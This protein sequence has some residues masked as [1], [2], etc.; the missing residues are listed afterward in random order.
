MGNTIY[1]GSRTDPTYILTNA[2]VRTVTAVLSSALIGDEL[3]IDQCSIGIITEA[4]LIAYGQFIPAG[5]SGLI[6]ADGLRFRSAIWGTGFRP[7]L[8]YGTPIYWESNGVLMGKFF[9]QSLDRTSQID[10]T[11]VAVSRVGLLD[12]Q[13][14][15]GG[16]YTGES[17]TTVLAD[18]LGDGVPYTIAPE[19]QGQSIYNWLPIASRRE[20][21]HQLLFA[22]GAMI[23]KDADGELYFGFPDPAIV[24]DV[25]DE[26][27]YTDGQSTTIQPTNRVELTEHS[28]YN[29]DTDEAVTLFDNSDGTSGSAA[30]QMVEFPDAPI[31]DLQASDGLTISWSNC[32]A[33][34]VSGI[35]ILTGKKYT[36]VTR[37]ITR[38][39]EGGDSNGVEPITKATLVSVANAENVADRL[40]NYYATAR[41]IYGSI[42]VRG[43]LPGQRVRLKD[44]FYEQTEAFIQSAELN[45]SGIL[46]GALQLIADYIPQKGGN[47]YTTSQLLTGSGTFTVP[48]GVTRLLAVLMSGGDGGGGGYDAPDLELPENPE[49]YTTTTSDLRRYQKGYSA[50]SLRGGDPGAAGTPGAGGKILIVTITVTPGQQI[51]YASGVGGEPG[52]AGLSPTAGSAG[53]DTTF[54]AY[55]SASGEK[56]ETGY[57]D[58]FTGAAY[59]APG[60]AGIAGARGAGYVDDG[61]GNYVANYP[62]LTVNGSTWTSG[63]SLIDQSASQSAGSY[64]T[65]KGSYRGQVYGSFGGG[66]AYGANGR[67]GMA[68]ESS[69]ITVS[70]SEATVRATIGGQGGTALPPDDSARVG[71][72]GSAGNGGGGAGAQGVAVAT[73]SAGTNASPGGLSTL[74]APRT[75]RKSPGGKGSRGGRGGPGGILLY[76]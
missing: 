58:Q 35:G 33:A 38:G 37:I 8:P 16:L 2:E 21:L 32:N 44:P 19:L 17:F 34:K 31:H 18:I 73:N 26:L 5:S 75:G 64:N 12:K 41:Q 39:P 20:N 65:N 6:T 76:Y 63:T 52:T 11:L 23:S 67:A 36:H 69:Q 51:A 45:S 22:M 43:E 10:F 49:T 1:I 30:D 27:V 40:Q 54:G 4:Y 29:L 46:R 48:A 3:P 61:N 57:I 24:A 55:T 15:M 42:V 70:T 50:Q 74:Y 59:A 13:Q 66:P 71:A 14:H 7:P 72:G 9:A 47:S 56:S 68:P 62:D 60:A 25:P 28:Y 53:T